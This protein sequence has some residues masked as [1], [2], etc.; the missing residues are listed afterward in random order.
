MTLICVPSA[1]SS[2]RVGMVSVSSAR[3]ES[4]RGGPRNLFQL[5]L[6]IHAAGRVDPGFPAF[7]DSDTLAAWLVL[8]AAGNLVLVADAGLHSRT[9]NS[10]SPSGPAR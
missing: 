1:R 8:Y 7:L 10:S 5:L 4:C 2:D 3:N 9:M 6:G